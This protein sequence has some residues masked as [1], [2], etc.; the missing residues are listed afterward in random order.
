VS[1]SNIEGA[2]P[3]SGTGYNVGTEY[4]VLEWVMTESV[5]E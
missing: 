5:A 3:F 1:D 2:L 4:I